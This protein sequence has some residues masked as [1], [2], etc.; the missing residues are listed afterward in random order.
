MGNYEELVVYYI[1]LSRSVTD[2]PVLDVWFDRSLDNVFQ[3]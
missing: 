3:Y 2:T 1:F